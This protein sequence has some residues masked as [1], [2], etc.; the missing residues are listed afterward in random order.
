MERIRGIGE[1]AGRA[2]MSLGLTSDHW[3]VLPVD[4]VR[5]ALDPVAYRTAAA[6]SLLSGLDEGTVVRVL[7]RMSAREANIT[8]R[9]FFDAP[10][11]YRL[12]NA[13][14]I[15]WSVRVGKAN[16]KWFR[17]KKRRERS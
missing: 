11:E 1:S 17:R 8:S 15:E 4:A 5:A 10:S 2:Q 6:I 16:A 14:E 12:S 3:G 13:E 7:E 9:C